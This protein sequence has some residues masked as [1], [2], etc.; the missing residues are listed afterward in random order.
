MNTSQF[1]NKK[2]IVAGGT[3]GIGLV[4]AQLFA[5]AGAA[6]TVTGRNAEK[7]KSSQQS[8]LNAA[9]VDSSDT[10]SL[11][12]FFKSHGTTD[13][14]VIALGGGKGLG[15]FADLSLQD[16]REGFEQKYWAHLATIK[17]A[18]PYMG[19]NG[20]IT[21]VTAITSSAK[22]PGTS[23]IGAMNG[24]LEIMVPILAKE[25]EQLRINAVSPG[26]VDTL[27]WDFLTLETKQETFDYYASQIPVG[28]IAQPGDVASV[29]LFL[30][31]NGYMTG[32]V[33]GCDGGLA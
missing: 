6:V 14:L 5:N 12:A 7:L 3:S 29:V 23:G 24:A 19:P 13:H 22:M 15:N 1:Q 9:Q 27:W 25:F 8:G 11:E 16:L 31:G 21:L 18:L 26:V 30:A 33:I 10:G 4:T 28:R 17:A 20:S 2:V 32:K